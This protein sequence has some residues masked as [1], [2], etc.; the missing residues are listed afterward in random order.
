MAY[1]AVFP[2]FIAD[3]FFNRGIELIRAARA[4]QS[5][6]L[7]P[8]FGSIL[9]VLF[10]GE[11]F[12][13]YHAIGIALI[14]AGIVLASIR[15]AS[16]S[17]PS[18]ASKSEDAPTFDRVALSPIRLEQAGQFIG[19][20]FLA[21]DQPLFVAIDRMGLK[22]VLL[23][24]VAEQRDR[25]LGIR[26][27]DAEQRQRLF[28]EF[29]AGV[30]VRAPT[31]SRPG[32]SAGACT[33]GRAPAPG[34]R[35][36]KIALHHLDHP[37]R[38]GRIVQG[39]DHQLRLLSAGRAQHVGSCRVTEVHLGSEATEHLHLAWITLQRCE[40]DAVHAQDAADDLTEAPQTADDH[41]CGGGIDRVVFRRRRTPQ[42]RQDRFG[43][44][45]QDRRGDHRCRGD[46]RGQCRVAGAQGIGGDS[47]SEA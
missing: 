14:A 24:V 26:L 29:Q 43:A 44:G 22:E 1:I 30:E 37:Q 32:R 11:T 2:S 19:R 34:W 3:L 40:F 9:A 23:V 41:R 7:T 6:H 25:A 5:W 39:H 12:Y 15:P 18:R 47:G 17:R 42:P 46:Q 31:R 45:E 33:S 36:G 4:G 8:V 20:S 10:L 28:R 27:A 35:G 13:L 38:T 16:T 21:L